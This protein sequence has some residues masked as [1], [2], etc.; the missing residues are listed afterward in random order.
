MSLIAILKQIFK[1]RYVS[2]T[3]KRRFLKKEEKNFQSK[4]ETNRYC[5]SAHICL[6]NSSILTL[7]NIWKKCKCALIIRSLVGIFF[8]WLK[9]AVSTYQH[10]IAQFIYFLINVEMWTYDVFCHIQVYK[11]TEKY[12]CIMMFQ[13]INVKQV[14]QWVFFWTCTKNLLLPYHPQL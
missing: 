12:N 1:A 5:C 9:S 10:N 14:K 7:N 3:Q 11:S 6:Y 8:L 13:I 2:D 4:S